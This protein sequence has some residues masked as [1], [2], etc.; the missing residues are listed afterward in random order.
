[1]KINIQP[2]WK[3]ISD[4]DLAGLVAWCEKWKIEEVY[5]TAFRQA[6][7]EG[8]SFNEWVSRNYPPLPIPVRAELKRAALIN[9]DRGRMFSL[10]MSHLVI[11]GFKFLC[12]H[13]VYGFLAFMFVYL[14]FS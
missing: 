3:E 12:R 4:V 14:I 10:Q 8:S 7:M 9:Y 6:G 11:Q 2:N 1:M 5:N 13:L